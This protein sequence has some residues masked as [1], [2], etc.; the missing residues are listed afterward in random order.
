MCGIAGVLRSDF[1]SE[2]LLDAL[3]HRGPDSRGHVEL[4]PCSLAATRLAIMD[5]RRDAD[6]PMTEGQT[7]IVLNGEIYNFA[8]LRLELSAYGWSFETSGDTEVVLKAILQ[9]GKEALSRLRGMY[10]LLAW[11]ADRQELWAARDRFGIKPLY[12]GLLRGGN[13]V[14]FSSEAT[15]LTE[16]VGRRVRPQAVGE[17]LHFGSPYSTNIFDDVFELPAGSLTIWKADGSISLHPIESA[18]TT[19][20][21]VQDLLADTV[22][23]HLISDRPVAL[24]LSGGFDS[25]LIASQAAV[26]APDALVAVT[27][28]TGHNPDDVAFASQTATHYG[29]PHRIIGYD[30]QEIVRLADA[31]FDLMDQPTVDGFNTYLVSD[32]ANT[33]GY[34]VALSGLGGDEAFGGYGYYGRSP[35]VAR[36]SRVVRRFPALIRDRVNQVVGA[37]TGRSGAQVAAIF[38]A[39][40]TAERYRAWRSLF[41]ATE[42]QRLT[43]CRPP[44][45]AILLGETDDEYR[46]LRTLDFELYL[47]STLLRD[48]DVFSMAC[49]VEV[50]VPLLDNSVVDHVVNQLP[51][52]SKRSIAA[53]LAD[54]FL[55]DIAHRRKIPFRLPWQDWLHVIDPLRDLLDA[56]DPWHGLVDPA[57]A[58]QMLHESA[59]NSVDRPLALLVLARWLHKLSVP[60]RI[61]KR[62][63]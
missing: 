31:Y 45:P 3:D 8:D 19:G 44:S 28:D 17:F 21:T 14:C 48:V 23:R 57:E 10:A 56:G 12:S 36:A 33:L 58:R 32:A 26:V 16:L 50:R 7:T 59:P 5:P 63:I 35:R 30:P 53:A 43:G 52:L 61:A 20:L 42:V 40:S 62:P 27:L 22:R 39:V 25:A 60:R 38:D 13:G 4:G 47:R 6:Q 37:R 9:W 34:P 11:H 2:M 1:S 18:P 54:P 55:V 15:A 24:F 41:T 51:H 49:G 29:M 46:D